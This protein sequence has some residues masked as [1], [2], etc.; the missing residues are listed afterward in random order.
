MQRIF[1]V[2]FAA[3]AFMGVSLPGQTI[4]GRDGIT[5]PPPPAAE[6]IP[7]TDN[8]FGTKIADSYR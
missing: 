8:Y 7:E 3:F 1:G 4:H 6:A 5:L 2:V